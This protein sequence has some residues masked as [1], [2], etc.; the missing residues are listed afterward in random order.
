VADQQ[1]E[2]RE[3]GGAGGGGRRGGGKSGDA[4]TFLSAP[5]KQERK[6]KGEEMDF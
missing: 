6:E 3:K 1:K 2:K 5:E 4:L